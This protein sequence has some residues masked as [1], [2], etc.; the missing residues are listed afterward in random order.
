MEL[1]VT[2][3]HLEITDAIKA[4][5]TD[6]ANKLPRYYDR[7]TSIEILLDKGV[8]QHYSVEMIIHVEHH[9]HMVATAEHEDLYAAIDAAVDKGERQLTDLKEK[10]RNRK[11]PVR[12]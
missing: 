11:H 3:K 5:A 6:K 7:V 2:G 8:K 4:Y 10:L 12:R 9:D 1:T